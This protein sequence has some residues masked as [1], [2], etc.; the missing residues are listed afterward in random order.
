MEHAGD[1]VEVEPGKHAG[2]EEVTREF[3]GSV[4]LNAQLLGPIPNV[5]ANFLLAAGSEDA[6]PIEDQD[7][8]AKGLQ[9]GEDVAGDKDA[10]AVSGE[11]LQGVGHFLAAHWFEAVHGLVEHEQ[12]RAVQQAL[13]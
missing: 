7:A 13:A 11:I 4:T 10:D 6:A 3:V 5:A 1:R 12:F 9:L 8:L 2:I